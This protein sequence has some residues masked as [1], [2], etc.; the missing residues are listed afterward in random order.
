MPYATKTKLYHYVV[1]DKQLFVSE[2][3]VKKY[4]SKLIVRFDDNGHWV[5]CPDE[6]DIGIIEHGTSLWLENRD[7]RIA[8]DLFLM[9][10]REHLRELQK[11]IDSEIKFI[12]YLQKDEL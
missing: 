8:K 11:Q 12:E 4:G 7:D 10:C 3:V 2:G 6:Y 5:M 1:R 9:Y